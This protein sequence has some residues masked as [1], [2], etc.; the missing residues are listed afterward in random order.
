M[1]LNH[2]QCSVFPLVY[3]RSLIKVHRHSSLDNRNLLS[4]FLD[5]KC[6]FQLEMD[7]DFFWGLPFRLGDVRLLSVFTQS[8]FLLYPFL[9]SSQK[10]IISVDFVPFPIILFQF[11]CLFKVSLPFPPFIPYYTHILRI[12]YLG[13]QYF[14]KRLLKHKVDRNYFLQS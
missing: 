11:N 12:Q 1:E 6:K 14:R 2:K 9:I 8:Y 3:R 10:D 13:F 4:Q 7:M 5:Q